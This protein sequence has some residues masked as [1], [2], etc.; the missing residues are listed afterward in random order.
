MCVNLK[1]YFTK[2]VVLMQ[3]ISVFSYS[4]VLL[5]HIGTEGGAWDI[6]KD[7]EIELETAA[8]AVYFWE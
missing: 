1:G 2:L 5:R 4:T 7:R 8:K 6:F 3:L